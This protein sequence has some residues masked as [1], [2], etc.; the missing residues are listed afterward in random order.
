MPA[1]SCDLQTHR[2]SFAGQIATLIVLSPDVIWRI[3]CFQYN[4]QAILKAIRAGVGFGSGT[5]TS[6]LSVAV[7]YMWAFKN[8]M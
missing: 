5:E 4:V 7:T 2:I 6:T 1:L 8:Y 3:Y